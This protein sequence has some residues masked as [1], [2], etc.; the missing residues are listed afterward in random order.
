MSNQVEYYNEKEQGKVTKETS[1]TLWF[2]YRKSL[3]LTKTTFSCR[4]NQKNIVGVRGK[5]SGAFKNASSFQWTP[6]IQGLMVLFLKASYYYQSGEKEKLEDP[7]LIGDVGSLASSLDAAQLKKV[8]WMCDLFGIHADGSL[9]LRRIL[10]ITNSGRK[11]PG[12]VMIGFNNIFLHPR[13]I[14]IFVNDN[15]V[16]NPNELMRYV[17]LLENSWRGNEMYFWKKNHSL[18][19]I[20]AV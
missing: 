2:N 9:I 1:L 16:S 14:F 6:A 7:I 10:R 3:E 17:E 18:H 8:F 15:I 4:L 12:G 13:N 5:S 11:Y 20:I 19:E